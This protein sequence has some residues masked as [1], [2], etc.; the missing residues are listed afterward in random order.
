MLVP[1]L[2][3]GSIA[4]AVGRLWGPEGGKVEGE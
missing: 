4:A 2:I 1:E 3:R